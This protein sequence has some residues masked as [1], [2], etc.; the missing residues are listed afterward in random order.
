MHQMTK[1]RKPGLGEDPD[2]VYWYEDGDRVF[3][4]SDYNCE[5]VEV[6]READ[7]RYPP[8]PDAEQ[9]VWQLSN[10]INA[11]GFHEPHRARGQPDPRVGRRRRAQRRA[12]RG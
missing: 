5:D 7:T 3:R 10:R 6:E 8:L 1:P 4:L 12:A 11:R 9:E 2:G